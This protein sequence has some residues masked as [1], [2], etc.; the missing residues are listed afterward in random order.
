MNKVTAFLTILVATVVLA[1]DYTKH[2]W[3]ELKGYERFLWGMLVSLALF[4]GLAV[5]V[6]PIVWEWGQY[7]ITLLNN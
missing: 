2:L 3:S 1:S 7:F 6:A 4:G 5:A